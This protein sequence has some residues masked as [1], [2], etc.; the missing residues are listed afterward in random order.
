MARKGLF[1]Y[2]ECDYRIHFEAAYRGCFFGIRL[3]LC[4][5]S[6]FSAS[7]ADFLL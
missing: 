3:P 4:M 2:A 7:G 6:L 5:D 1:A